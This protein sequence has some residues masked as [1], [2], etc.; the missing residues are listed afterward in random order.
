MNVFKSDVDDTLD[1][2]CNKFNKRTWARMVPHSLLI[3]YLSLNAMQFLFGS[4]KVGFIGLL[5]H[6]RELEKTG[7]YR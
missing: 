6:P 1:K 3:N 7:D 2:W 4:F 5:Q